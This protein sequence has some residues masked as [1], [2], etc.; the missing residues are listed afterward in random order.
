LHLVLFG[1]EQKTEDLNMQLVPPNMFRL[2]FGPCNA[3][4]KGPCKKLSFKKVSRPT[5]PLK[6]LANYSTFA[7]CHIHDNT[8]N[9]ENKTILF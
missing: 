8:H 6:W 7:T 2:T 4:L 5:K 9:I 3:F 1:L